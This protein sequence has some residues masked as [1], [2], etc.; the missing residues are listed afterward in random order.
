MTLI[1]PHFTFNNCSFTKTLDNLNQNVLSNDCLNFFGM[2]ALLIQFCENVPGFWQPFDFRSCLRKVNTLETLEMH[3]HLD[4]DVSNRCLTIHVWDFFNILSFLSTSLIFSEKG[5]DWPLMTT[6][7]TSTKVWLLLA[8]YL[9]MDAWVNSSDE[10]KGT[11]KKEFVMAKDK[12]CFLVCYCGLKMV[13]YYTQHM[14]WIE[15][16][17]L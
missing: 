3:L 10:A 17:N 16:T 5:K 7:L 13:A 9:M 12:M 11:E 14:Q 4:S 6:L 15:M 8:S 1:L 2:D